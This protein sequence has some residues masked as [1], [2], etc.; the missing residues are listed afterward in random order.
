MESL[1]AMTN[2]G[3]A[4]CWKGAR[5][6]SS[7][8]QDDVHL[9]TIHLTDGVA[10]SW[11]N[12]LNFSCP[13][14]SKTKGPDDR[15]LGRERGREKGSEIERTML[16]LCRGKKKQQ[17]PSCLWSMF[18]VIIGPWVQGLT[19]DHGYFNTADRTL[20]GRAAVATSLVTVDS[21]ARHTEASL[22][23]ARPHGRRIWWPVRG[24]KSEI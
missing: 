24:R 13:C 3:C 18:P 16:C 5:S 6:W 8:V 15:A 7:F 14:T 17:R 23:E 12:S 22:G 21:P 10:V 4:A 11:P 9:G 2:T 20:A 1:G 19:D